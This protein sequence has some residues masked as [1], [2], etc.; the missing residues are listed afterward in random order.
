MSFFSNLVNNFL[1]TSPWK[2]EWQEDLSNSLKE[3]QAGIPLN[4]VVIIARESDLYTEVLFILSFLGLSIGS[5]LAYALRQSGLQVDELLMIPLVGFSLGATIYAFRKYYISKMAPRAVRERVAEKAKGQFFD[6]LQNVKQKLSL[7]YISEVEKEA[8]MFSSPDISHLI[9]AKEIQK[10]LSK[11]VIN[12]S[13]GRP[14]DTLRPAL[15]EMGQLLRSAFNS[16]GK[17]GPQI[18]T[19]P[20]EPIFIRASD[21]KSSTEQKVHVLKGSKDIN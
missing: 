18:P 6:H 14:L 17:E 8:F 4:L 12:Y 1:G 11:L 5:I 7:I 20:T 13:M 19:R 21:R 3:A 16:S 9:P 10:T 15:L 2:K